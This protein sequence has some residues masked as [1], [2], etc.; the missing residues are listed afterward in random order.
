MRS[1]FQFIIIS[2]LIA[3]AILAFIEHGLE[4]NYV[5]KTA[6]KICLFFITIWIYIK[7][8]KDFRFRDV[9]LIH[10]MEKK[11]W[12]RLAVLGLSSAGIVLIAYLALQPFFDAAVIKEDLTNRLGINATGFVFVGL[13]I[14][15]G[16]S[17]LEEYFFRGFIFYNL[18]KKLGYIY[19][20]VL[21]ASYHIP[22]IML[23]FSPV[24]ILVCF[25][26]LWI[27]GLVFHMVNEKNKTIWS[28]W[29]IHIF[30]DIMIIAIGLTIFF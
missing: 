8:F 3:C 29:I 6:A 12:I 16:N 13:Y 24:L 14:S 9:L 5:I 28:S 26:G 27:I 17:F 23:W 7:I 10:K 15:L 11:D 22:M 20:P 4:I 25:I 2:T 30:A 19:S 18:P 1:K 21:F